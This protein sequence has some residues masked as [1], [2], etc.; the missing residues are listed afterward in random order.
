MRLTARESPW[1]QWRLLTQLSL[2]TT[3]TSWLASALCP[4]E[5]PRATACEVS[6]A[7]RWLLALGSSHRSAYTTLIDRE[8]ERG[9]T[10]DRWRVPGTRDF[11]TNRTDPRAS[12]HDSAGEVRRR[13]RLPLPS[14]QRL[15]AAATSTRR[16]SSRS[17]GWTS[18]VL[19]RS[20]SAST[21][22]STTAT[23][24]HSPPWRARPPRSRS[25]CGSRRTSRSSRSRIRFGS[26]KTSRYSIS[27]RAAA[28]SSAWASGTRPRVP[29]VRLPGVASCLAH[30]GVRRHPAAWRGRASASATQA[31]GTTFDDVRVTPEPV[32]SGGPPLW[33]A[34]S[35]GPSV[36][37]G[38]PPRDA[39][40]AAGPGLVSRRLAREG[41]AA[42]ADPR[43]E[44]N[45]DHPL[46]PRDRGSGPRL[47]AVAC[48]RAVPNGGL[49]ALLRG[50]G[51]GDART[52]NEPGADHQRV[53]V[54]N[55]DECVAELTSFIQRYG[56][57]DVVTWGS[58]PGL[59]PAALTASME[60]FAAEVVP[61][62]RSRLT[63]TTDPRP[64]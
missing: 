55:V 54:G 41:L 28:S 56:L 24:R 18:S 9:A 60:R 49:R 27:C 15:H 57:T 19:M 11:G 59:Q 62:V 34:V 33:M 1:V 61:Q 4:K 35:S 50:G 25:G 47:A 2:P 6:V 46:V 43:R 17:L 58:A 7:S 5:M 30:R 38:R 8:H 63:S 26:P 29:R 42:G 13:A 31:S 3:S 32:Q 21:T 37:T 20:G 39:C 53:F 51:H 36:G 48:R 16:P 10:G 12:S 14:R 44:A 52:F 23:C 45:R 40:P 64:P 22:S